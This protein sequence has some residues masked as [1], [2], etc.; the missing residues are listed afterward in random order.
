MDLVMP[1]RSLQERLLPAPKSHNRRARG[2][3]P[4][5]ILERL[6]RWVNAMS[7]ALATAKVRRGAG[8]EAGLAAAHTAN[9]TAPR[10]EA[11]PTKPKVMTARNHT[12]SMGNTR[13]ADTPSTAPRSVATPLPPLRPCH[14]G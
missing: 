11:S 3:V 1:R 5:C 4:A 10:L 8:G 13:A 7:S 9:A 6:E 14:K 12:T 2:S